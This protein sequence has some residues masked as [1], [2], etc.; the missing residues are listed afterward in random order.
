LPSRCSTSST[1]AHTIRADQWQAQIRTH[2]QSDVHV[3]DNKFAPAASPGWHSH[4]GPG[5]ILVLSGTVTNY[6]AS[7]P[8]APG[9]REAWEAG[10][11]SSFFHDVDLDPSLSTGA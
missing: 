7:D 5:L 9:L 8:P 11:R 4:P 2:G 3:V 1:Y 10:D 6:E